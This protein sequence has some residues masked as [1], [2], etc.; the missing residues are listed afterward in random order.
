MIK[1]F[2]GNILDIET[3]IIV[4][5]C[6]CHG[7]MGAGIALQIMNRFPKAFEVYRKGNLQLGYIT[8]AEVAP[9]KWIIN[10]NTQKSTGMGKQVSYDAIEEAFAR[11]VTFQKNFKDIT[12]VDLPICFP[13]IGAGLGG[14]N[15]EIISTIIDQTVPD[16]IEKRLYTL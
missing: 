4:H 2:K 12:E 13:M 16:N 9:Q 1:T 5:G 14:G 7:V 6:N 3:G 8:H 11:V 10:A 15:W